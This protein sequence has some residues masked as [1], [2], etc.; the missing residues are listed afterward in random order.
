MAIHIA[1]PSLSSADTFAM[2]RG[3]RVAVDCTTFSSAEPFAPDRDEYE[4]REYFR[5]PK[6][7][8]VVENDDRGGDAA[9]A[10][11]RYVLFGLGLFTRFYCLSWPRQVVFDE[12]HF[13][14]FVS[15][16]MTGRYYFDIHPPLGKLLIAPVVWFSGYD[17][18]QAFEKIGEQY[19]GVSV[20]ALRVVPATFGALLVPL[21]HSLARQLGASPLAAL[22]AACL[23][24]LDGAALVESRLL[25]TDS[26]LFFFECLQLLHC[27]RASAAPPLSRRFHCH[28]CLCGLSI[29]AAVSIKWTAL[30]TMA[31]VGLESARCLLSAL[32][33]AIESASARVHGNRARHLG[34]GG[35][36]R[37]VLLETVARL[38]WLLVLPAIVYLLCFVIH[39]RY[40]PFTG[41][42]DRFHDVNFRC[43]LRFPPTIRHV[44]QPIAMAADSLPRSPPLPESLHGCQVHGCDGC[45]GVETYGM[46]A[47][48]V[49]LNSAMLSFNAGIKKGHAFGSGWLHWPLNSKP[50]LY[51]KS[52]DAVGAVPGQ[53]A[54]IYMAGNPI[55]WA[56]ALAGGVLMA[57]LLLFVLLCGGR[58]AWFTLCC[59]HREAAGLNPS[60][61]NG[62]GDAADAER[63]WGSVES[64]CGCG[65]ASGGGFD[66]EA[67]AP[68]ASCNRKEPPFLP[69]PPSANSALMSG[70]TDDIAAF[71]WPTV[72]TPLSPDLPHVPSA[73]AAHGIGRGSALPLRRGSALLHNGWL[74]LATHL[75][76]WLPFALVRRVAFL[77]HYIPQLLISFQ[78]TALA[79]DELTRRLAGGG[80]TGGAN[81]KSCRRLARL[82]ACLACFLLLPVACS[83]LH[84][85]PLFY[86]WPLQPDDLQRRTDRLDLS[87][88]LK[89]T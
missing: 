46:L 72:S 58:A 36:I 65:R 25:V 48:I 77:Y 53:Q 79:F 28:L 32:C 1:G 63:T 74:L 42:G 11:V 52:E 38:L 67:T 85:A 21:S 37:A 34:A 45:E 6:P 55:V 78:M 26:A 15:S 44:D 86:G 40:L 29:G 59:G 88:L 12:V 20:Y 80:G 8:P 16:Y 4:R 54:R 31:A 49:A 7:R 62:C 69:A 56:L 60:A 75:M 87:S 41:A 43:R 2:R 89:S 64:S 9:D 30:A 19:E 5:P 14:K 22:L 27:L 33:L 81:S 24:L 57:A 17:G 71:G 3:A 82:R 50:V 76:G 61:S 70:A 10:I 35:R 13:G 83:S 66:L 68:I 47:A 39:L 51:W 84:F 73:V 18:H 23:V